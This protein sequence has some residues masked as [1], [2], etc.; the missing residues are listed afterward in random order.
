[1]SKSGFVWYLVRRLATMA[2]LLVVVSFLI[3]SLTYLSPGSPVDVLL[4][5][6]TRTSEAVA[7]LNAKY[8]LQDPFFAQYWYWLTNALHLDFGTSILSSLPVGDQIGDRLPV[9]LFLGG[10]AYVL[11]M[12]FG[13]IPGIVAA[14]K[15]GTAFDRSTVAASIVAL[16]APAF[17]TGVFALYLFAV[18]LPVFPVAGMGTGF[19]DGLWHL[20][21]PAIALALS[22]M[23]LMVR[24]T[25]AAMI[26]V[27]DQDYVTFARA[28]GLSSRRVLVTYALRNALIPVVTI[29][30]ALLAAVIIGGVIVEQTFSLNGVGSLLIQSVETKDV[31]T[32]QGVALVVAAIIVVANLLADLTYLVV[33][34]RIRLGRHAQ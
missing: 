29:S 34:P 14:V 5:P 23:A 32:I 19:V 18:V 13:I 8:H 24:H 12:V 10:Y 26:G 3:F 25:R 15:R 33:D 31:P 4:G 6:N 21:L 9:S 30:G 7:A 27:L 1:M 2:L 17:V 11:T 16:S 20:T 22:V 28:R